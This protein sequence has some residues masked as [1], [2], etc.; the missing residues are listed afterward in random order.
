MLR[1]STPSALHDV[2]DVEDELK[3]CLSYLQMQKVRF[4]EM[5]H[6]SITNPQLHSAKGKLP[7]YSLQLLAENA[8]KHNSFTNEQPLNI[9]IDYDGLTE[10][11]TVRNKIQPKRMKE[12][13]T[14]IGLKNLDERY[15]LLSK[16]TISVENDANE[17]AVKIKILPANQNTA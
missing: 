13:T 17:F 3:L 7:V 9:F 10:T 15:Q 12:V 11:I 1:F 6:F 14:K 16:E 8:I 2:V 5:L 4:G